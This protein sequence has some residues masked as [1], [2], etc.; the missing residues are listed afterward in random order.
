M[1]IPSLRYLMN[2]LKFK[3]TEWTSLSEKDKEE[4]KQWADEEQKALG[5]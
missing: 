1:P 2:E 5:L 4:L 3:T